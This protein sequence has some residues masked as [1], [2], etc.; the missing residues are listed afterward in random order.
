MAYRASGTE[1]SAK[2]AHHGLANGTTK[3]PSSIQEGKMTPACGAGQYLGQAKNKSDATRAPYSME[4]IHGTQC[5]IF[6]TKSPTMKQHSLAC[7]PTFVARAPTE[8][9]SKIDA[10]ISFHF[11]AVLVHSHHIR[12]LYIVT[13]IHAINDMGPMGMVKQLHGILT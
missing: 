6:R 4:Q 10:T 3:V 13:N 9:S 5:A 1:S 7:I 12:E 2:M 11:H 8:L